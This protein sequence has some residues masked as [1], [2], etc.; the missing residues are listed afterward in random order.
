MTDVLPADER[1]DSNQVRDLEF[2]KYR[3]WVS[4]R[5]VIPPV[6]PQSATGKTERAQKDVRSVIARFQDVDPAL[7]DGGG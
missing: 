5:G 6:Q 4:S 3:S 2:Q 7:P 1:A